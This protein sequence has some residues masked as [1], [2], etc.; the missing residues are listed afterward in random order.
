MDDGQESSARP[1]Q[2]VRAG[3]NER[4]HPPRT[5]RLSS[6]QVVVGEL[7]RR[8]HGDLSRHHLQGILPVL[9]GKVPLQ[10]LFLPEDDLLWAV[11]L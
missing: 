2:N 6:S 11:L 7:L 3:Q 4:E 10:V 5:G 1:T 9:R 8:L